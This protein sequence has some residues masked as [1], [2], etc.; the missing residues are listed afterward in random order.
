MIYLI[1]L[2]I[3]FI[4]CQIVVTK[5]TKIKLFIK[6]KNSA[7][8]MLIG[9]IAIFLSLVICIAFK[10]NWMLP[11]LVTIFMCSIISEK[12]RQSFEDMEKG[13]KV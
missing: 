13:K 12:Y 4:F 9:M 8:I 2:A 10:V 11:A 6:R 3:S 1:L 7:S 5:I